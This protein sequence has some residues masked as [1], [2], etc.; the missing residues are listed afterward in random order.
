M[1]Q[2]RAHF[3][4]LAIAVGLASAALL[5]LSTTGTLS[6][7]VASIYN[8][9]NTAASGSV[10]MTETTSSGS[11]T[12]CTSGISTTAVTCAINKFGGSTTMVPGSSVATTINIAN[13]GSGAVG[14]FTLVS[15]TAGGATCAVSANGS[16]NGTATDANVCAK[17]NLTIASGST[18]LFTG[19]LASF[20]ARTTAISLNSLIPT[21]G[22]ASVPFTFTVSL[23]SSAD[24]TY[25]GK[26]ASVPM[27][28]AFS[29]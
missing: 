10:V 8:N 3:A 6:A 27:T 21:A 2:K 24:N 14:T 29:S 28:W 7:F 26:T 18:T 4:P 16:N 9:A 5:G 13:T 15:G 17:F 22:G 1:K 19:T 25:E 20:A 12:S 11:T 23:D